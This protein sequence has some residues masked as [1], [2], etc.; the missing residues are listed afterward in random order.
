MPTR[1]RRPDADRPHDAVAQPHDRIDRG[2][3]DARRVPPPSARPDRR[4]HRGGRRRAPGL[5]PVA[6]GRVSGPADR[7][8]QAGLRSPV[9]ARRPARRVRPRRGDLGRR[10]GWLAPDQGRRQA[11]W[12]PRPALVAR[13]PPSRVPVTPP[14]LDPDLADRCAGPAARPAGD[15]AEAAAPDRPDGERRRRRRV[16]VGA[17]RAPAGGDGPARAERRGDR[18]DRLRR[19]RDRRDAR[20]GRRAER[21]RRWSLGAATVRCCTSRMPTAGSR[22]FA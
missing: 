8:G 11:R 21:R 14:R 20:R 9:V 16:R 22:S 2:G 18:A 1:V 17:G 15:R 5:H 3:R 19:R 4:L 13:R 6:A 12:W 7:L 10:D